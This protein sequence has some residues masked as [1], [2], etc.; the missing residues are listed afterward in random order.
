M[1]R[2]NKKNEIMH[3]SD[4]SAVVEA[5]F[6]F[7]IMFMVFFALVL[8]ALYLPQRAML[9]RA[10]QFAATAVATEM[11]DVWIYYDGE[12]QTF[13]RYADHDALRDDKGGVYVTLFSSVVGGGVE[14]GESTVER[15]DEKENV[16]VISNG[17]LTVECALVNYVVYKEVV[18]TATRSIPVPVDFSVVK[19]PGTI[20]LT[21]TSKAVVKN[22]DEFIRNVDIAVDF[23][24][25]V[26]EKFPAVNTVGDIFDKVN[27]AGD[28]ISGFFGI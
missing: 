22:G 8:L 13:G 27:E 16:S 11:S 28:K 18:V 26:R 21:V 3:N 9:Q 19:F 6:V 7:P 24:K 14:D 25:F 10:S 4:G 15:L 20:N 1:Q 2:F 5:T 23:L 12:T 17:E